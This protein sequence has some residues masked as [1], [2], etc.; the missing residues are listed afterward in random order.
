RA[1]ACRGLQAPRAFRGQDPEGNRSQQHTHR[2]GRKNR[3]DAEYAGGE[4][5]GARPPAVDP[6]AR[7]PGD[8]VNLRAPLFLKY[9]AYC[10]ALV[11]GAVLAT[12]AI[13][14]YS[15]HQEIRDGSVKLL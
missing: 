15:A 8:R 4:G 2:A 9:F 12:G 7:R 3:V 13:S 5:A 1:F 6:A 14:L 11:C 10:A